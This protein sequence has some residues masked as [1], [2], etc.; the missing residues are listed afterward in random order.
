MD[1]TNQLSP[2]IAGIPKRAGGGTKQP[3]RPRGE[4]WDEIR[5]AYCE[6]PVRPTFRELS[7]RFNTPERTIATAAF[8]QGWPILRA[9]AMETKLEQAG[10]RETIAQALQA[11]KAIVS[12]GENVGMTLLQKIAALSQDLED[13]AISSR[14]NLVNTL[15][16]ALANTT[17]AMKDLGIVGFAGKLKG[18]G[19]QGNGRFDPKQLVQVNLAIQNLVSKTPGAEPV[20]II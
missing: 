9:N 8:D 10:A 18:E 12:T 6:A 19:D 13:G 15:S 3:F 1:S 4:H 7:D 14:V 16:F 5:K 20:D 11:S 17:R 2:F